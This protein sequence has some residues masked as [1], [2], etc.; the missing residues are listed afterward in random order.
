MGLRISALT[1]SP[2]DSMYAELNKTMIFIVHPIIIIALQNSL[3]S[4]HSMIVF[5]M[6]N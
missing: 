3:L 5:Y 4:V 2:G 6:N 1:S